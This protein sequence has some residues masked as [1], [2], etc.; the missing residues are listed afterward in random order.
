MDAKEAT[1]KLKLIPQWR[2]AYKYVSVQLAALLAIL[3]SIEPFLPQITAYLPIHW[4][5]YLSVAILVA[6]V[7]QQA[8]V[9][10]TETKDVS[11]DS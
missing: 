4:Q 7:I 5:A 11:K 1:V 10:V 9:A 2:Q 6:R 8:K 3:V